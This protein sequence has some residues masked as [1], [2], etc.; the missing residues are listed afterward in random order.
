MKL[1]DHLDQTGEQPLSGSGATHGAD[2]L[3]RG[4]RLLRSL[5]PPPL[6]PRRATG[7]K[8]APPPVNSP[9]DRVSVSLEAAYL[10]VGDRFDPRKL[11]P[12]ELTDMTELML[13]GRI[14]TRP[15]QDLLLRGPNGRGYPMTEAGRPRNLIAEWQ[16]ALAR[17]VGRSFLAEVSKATRALGILGRI[18]ATRMPQ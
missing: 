18:A 5:P 7:K 11:T 16:H 1:I 3:M 10:M 2:G 8:P 15:E 13:A 6:P 4:Q 9:D 12:N 17:A 14:I